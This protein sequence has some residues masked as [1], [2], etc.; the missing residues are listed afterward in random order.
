MEIFFATLMGAFVS[1]IGVLLTLRHNQKTHKQNLAEERRKRKEGREFKAKQDSLIH[2]AEAF[3]HFLTYY[4]TI[5][6]R[7][8]PRDGSVAPGVTEIGVAL[9]KLH[10]YCS[11]TTIESSTRL[12]EVLDEVVAEAM[13]ARMPSAFIDEDLKAIDVEIS[14]LEKSNAVL[15][16]EIRGLLFSNPQSPIIASHRNQLSQS[17]QRIAECHNKKLALF[18]RKY[19][20]TEAC[21]DVV[22]RNLRTISEASRD[23]LLLAREELAFPI[24][25]KRYRTIMDKRIESMEKNLEDLFSHIRKEVEQKMQ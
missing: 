15:Q 1:L 25:E 23:F 7:P 3:S 20:K 16:E 5:P 19:R 6:D 22:A 8:L 4:M 13:K 18:K 9:T 11:L 24:D 12:G 10:F 21:R 17:H 2:A 14:G